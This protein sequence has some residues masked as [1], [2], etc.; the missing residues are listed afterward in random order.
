M[1]SGYQM[2][3]VALAADVDCERLL[4]GLLPRH[5]SLAIRP[6][7][8]DYLVH[9]KQDTGCLRRSS[10]LLRRYTRSHAHAL[11]LFDRQGCGRESLS[12]VELEKE[13]ETEL[14]A[15]GWEDRAAV[16]VLDPELEIWV[17]SGS[18]QVDL[19]LG[20]AAH[21]P[22][23]RSWLIERGFLTGRSVKPSQPK[24][25]LQEALRVSHRVRSSRIYQ[26]LA[27]RV[28]LSRCTDPAFLKLK[29][30]LQSWFPPEH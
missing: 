30:V 5:Q 23:L 22:D 6:V 3:L 8:V 11:V 1:N 24:E 18:S 14:H 27:S 15:C 28:S 10:E 16:I 12:R 19:A 2:D 9:T 21:H 17:W 25:A 26:D 29:S 7:T 13:V 4:R 20:W